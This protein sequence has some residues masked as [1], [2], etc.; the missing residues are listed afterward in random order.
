MQRIILRIAVAALA[1]AAAPIFAGDFY[2]QFLLAACPS[3]NPARSRVV[4]TAKG[5]GVRHKEGSIQDVVI[6]CQIHAVFGNYFNWLQLIAE[7]NTP[8]AYAQATLWRTS[9]LSPSAPEALFSTTTS[10]KPGVQIAFND[11]LDGTLDVSD[12]VFWIEVR[13]VRTTATASVIA[14]TAGLLDVF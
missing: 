14:Y 3:A 10:D 4:V 2:E 1:F 5:P 11:Q 9:I 7:D 13:L 8:D 12:Y 6:Y